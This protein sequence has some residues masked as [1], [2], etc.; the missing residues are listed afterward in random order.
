MFLGEYS[1]NLDDK[2]RLPLPAPWRT[3][4]GDSVII[5]RGTERCLLVFRADDLKQFL[6]K[7]DKVG[8]TGSD[9]RELTRY[10]SS[11]AQEEK[12]DKYGRITI[13][14][15]LIDFAEIKGELLVVGAYDHGE[16]WSSELYHQADADLVKN[17]P[18]IS[19][20]VNQAFQR[21]HARS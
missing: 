10:F 21:M 20:R 13:P 1:H 6:D 8:I 16:V 7:I 2:G 3:Q 17:V 4:L 5:T 9:T 19:E 15:N 12:P 14:Q 18:D 11:K